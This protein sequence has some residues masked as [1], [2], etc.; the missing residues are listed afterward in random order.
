[1]GSAWFL[2]LCS[3]ELKNLASIYQTDLPAPFSNNRA[4]LLE[5]HYEPGEL[6][7]SP[8]DALNQPKYLNTVEDMQHNLG[9]IM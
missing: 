3:K 5:A 7:D 2:V 4:A 6:P 1:M 9:Y 8:I